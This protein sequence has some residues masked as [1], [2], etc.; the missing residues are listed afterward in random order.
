MAWYL[1]KYS[2]NNEY[3]ELEN[4]AR[5]NRIGIWSEPNPIAPWNWGKENYNIN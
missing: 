1:K 5:N 4:E 2:N 3:A